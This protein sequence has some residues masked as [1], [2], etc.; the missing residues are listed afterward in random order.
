[1]NSANAHVIESKV[2]HTSTDMI[3]TSELKVTCDT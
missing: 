1:M 3:L 2:T